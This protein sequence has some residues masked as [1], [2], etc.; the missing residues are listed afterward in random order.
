M[1]VNSF[2]LVIYLVIFSCSD[3]KMKEK[4]RRRL[5]EKIEIKTVINPLFHLSPVLTKIFWYEDQI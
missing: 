1:Y 3:F 5:K 4:R 2:I